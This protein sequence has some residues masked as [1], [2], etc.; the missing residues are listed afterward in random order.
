MDHTVWEGT[1][2]CGYPVMTFS[3]GMLVYENGQFLGKAGYG[4]YLKRA[5]YSRK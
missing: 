5:P 4:K 1:E 3:R 2:L